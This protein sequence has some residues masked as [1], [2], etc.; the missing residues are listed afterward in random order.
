MF[1]LSLFF[2]KNSQLKIIHISRKAQSEINILEWQ[3]LLPPKLQS[4]NIN[5]LQHSS[6]KLYSVINTCKFK[7]TQQLMWHTG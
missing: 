3:T 6:R 1:F 5:K 4:T 7:F 2:L